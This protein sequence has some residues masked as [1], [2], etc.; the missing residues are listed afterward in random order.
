[1]FYIFPLVFPTV[2]R[3]LESKNI[4]T[5]EEN[6]V[7]GKKRS[8]QYF[9]KVLNIKGLEFRKVDPFLSDFVRTHLGK[10]SVIRNELIKKY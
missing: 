6:C 9:L 7:P 5:G 2:K 10:H 3:N 4:K 1:M 8:V